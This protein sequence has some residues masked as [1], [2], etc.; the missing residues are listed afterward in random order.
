MLSTPVVFLIYRRPQNTQ[1]VFDEIKKARPKKLFVVADGAKNEEERPLCEATRAIIQQV[2][3]DCDVQTNFAEANMGLRKR[4]SSGLDW[5]FS[6]VERAI[7]LEDDCLPHPTFF[8][9][10]EEL[11]DKYQHDERVMHICGDNFGYK[12]ARGV[13]DSYYFSTFIHVWGWATWRRAWAHYDVEMTSWEQEKEQVLARFST[14]ADHEYWREQWDKTKAYQIK[15]WD[16]QWMYACMRHEGLGIL[17]YENQIS[18][19]GM[20]ADSTNTADAQ[21]PLANLPTEDIVFPLVHPKEVKR[22]VVAEGRT[23]WLFWRHQKGIFTRVL[24]KVLMVWGKR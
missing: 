12:R 2:D 13:Q 14:K 5:V 16:Y 11:L 24:F 22:N 19:I 3:W 4:I 10:C 21:S 15:T 6:H 18:N 9:F 17:P 7:I 20:G 1:R 23:A 8:H